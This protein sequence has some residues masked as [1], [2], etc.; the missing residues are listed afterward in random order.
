M[1]L[2]LD[3]S[4]RPGTAWSTL[5]LIVGCRLLAILLKLMYAVG[6]LMQSIKRAGECFRVLLFGVSFYCHV[7]RRISYVG[8][9]SVQEPWWLG[10]PMYRI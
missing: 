4:C 1:R 2:A 5:T 10:T 9:W 3:D 8:K 7:R 6:V